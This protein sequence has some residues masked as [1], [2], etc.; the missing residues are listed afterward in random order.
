[1]RFRIKKLDKNKHQDIVSCAAW[2]NANE[3]FR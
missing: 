2:S 1:M 3:L